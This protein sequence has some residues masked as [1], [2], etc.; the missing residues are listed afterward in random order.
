MSRIIL[1]KSR[2]RELIL[3]RPGD[4]FDNTPSSEAEAYHD[5]KVR[6]CIESAYKVL[7][8]SC[9]S[10][11]HAV[12][13]RVCDASAR[14]MFALPAIDHIVH[15][16]WFFTVDGVLDGTKF[17]RGLFEGEPIIVSA[18]SLR[19]AREIAEEGLRAAI[20][21]ARQVVEE[22]IPKDFA[23]SG[24]LEIEGGVRKPVQ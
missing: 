9:L 4:A 12:L 20:A 19:H 23:N 13:H 11:P 1:P 15:G 14:F 2:E 8:A 10:Y 5:R 17:E 16:I 21:H 18:P 6:A 22:G 7:R 3:E 24:G